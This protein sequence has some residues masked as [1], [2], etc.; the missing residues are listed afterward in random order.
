MKKP[1]VAMPFRHHA[2]HV[3]EEARKM[4]TDAGFELR[5]NDTGRVLSPEEQHEMI[6]DAFGVIAGTEKYPKEMIEGCDNLKVII[7]FGVGTD[8]FDLAAMKEKNIA[9]GVIANYNAVAEFTLTLM[10]NAIKNYSQLDCAV[11]KGLWSRFPMREITDKTVGLIGFGRIGKRVAE[12]LAPFHVRLLVSDPYAEKEVIKRFGGE[13]V[14][15]DELLA[16]SDIVSLHLPSTPDTFH[17]IDAEKIAKMKDGAILVN[18]ARGALVDQAA[19]VEALQS[20]KLAS[21]GI[22]VYEK[23][24]VTPENPLF[25]IP[26]T[27]LTPHCSAITLETNYNGGLTSAESIIRVRDGG[28]PVYPVR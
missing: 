21:A 22:D 9:V 12:L 14:S 13:A 19:L 20:G 11:R 8:N 18:T 4:L 25:A 5:C 23:E 15:L 3:C 1:I 24:P 6:K 26:N 16:A 28:T 10:L 27:A 2:T 17:F 7:R